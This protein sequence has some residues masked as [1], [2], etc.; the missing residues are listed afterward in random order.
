M[1]KFILFNKVVSICI[2]TLILSVLAFGQSDAV[3]TDLNK[4]FKKFNVVRFNDNGELRRAEAGQSISVPTADKNYELNLT[5]HDL[6]TAA[7]RAE[8]TN[9]I[10]SFPLERSAAT[11]YKGTIAGENGS[12]VRLT[13]DGS[14]I[15]GYFMTATGRRFF[16]EPATNYSRAANARDSVVFETTDMVKS[17]EFVCHSELEDKIERGKELIGSRSVEAFTTT[18]VIEIA[19]ETDFAFV[20]ALGG[21]A[22]AN[23]EVLSILNMIEGD[24]ET[25][26]GLSF[27]VVFQ[28]AWTSQDPFNGA[29]PSAMLNSFLNYWNTNYPQSSVSR[30][31]A[32]IWTSRVNL[33]GQGLSKLGVICSNPASSYGMSGRINYE[34]IQYVL[35]AHEIGHNLNANHAT[36]VQGCDNTIMSPVVSNLTPLDF[37]QFS[38]SEIINFT[39]ANGSC[40][41]ERTVVP[42]EF[43]YDGD[44]KSDVSVFRPSN[45]VWY[46]NRSSAGFIGAAFGVGSDKIVPADYDGDGV[47]DI[48]VYRSGSWYLQRSRLGFTGIVFGDGDDIPAP[49]DYDGDNKAD[50]AVFRP[51]NGAWYVQGSRTGFYSV[52]FGQRGDVPVPADYDGDNKADINVFRPSNGGWYRLNSSNNQFYGALFGQ[53]G[54]KAL[55]A[56][57]DGDG[58]TD[59]AIY[60]PSN[61]GW[62][63]ITS[64]NNS[65]AATSFGNAAD[66]PTAADYDGDGKT[67]IAVYRPSNGVWYRY[68]SGNGAFVGISFGTGTDL[69]TQSF[70]LP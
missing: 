13:I 40:L 69:P 45:G 66:F 27:D 37:C 6:R 52:P 54:D 50:I 34:S 26:L 70:Y 5:P 23:N 1:S 48:A 44:G 4:S 47:T 7:F 43:D 60:R 64:S 67:D 65:F 22:Q 24:Y 20:T 33:L 12:K 51:S 28:H 46:L 59:L 49:A 19:T 25:Q 30:D 63:R 41:S 68:N 56:D 18:R 39:A 29:S 32:H 38:R 42:T 36:I 17:V 57:F 2:Y 53:N 14:K 55:A 35:S 61:G 16:V 8:E 9:Q 62:Y 21:A 58:K 11:T 3:R 15:E 31:T 10:G